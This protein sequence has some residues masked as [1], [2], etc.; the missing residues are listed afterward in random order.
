MNGTELRLL[1]KEVLQVGRKENWKRKKSCYL[2]V[3][4]L[5]DES[6]LLNLYLR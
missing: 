5:T 2:A 1:K 6:Q 3:L 4:I